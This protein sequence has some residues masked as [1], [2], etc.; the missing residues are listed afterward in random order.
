M[1]VC[2]YVCVCVCVWMYV[3]SVFVCPFGSAGSSFP[4]VF[5]FGP[6]VL[7]E[8]GRGRRRRRRLLSSVLA[9]CSGVTSLF[10]KFAS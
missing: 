8:L 4:L 5:P 10:G 6:P 7:S 9:V 1:C 2:V 3:L